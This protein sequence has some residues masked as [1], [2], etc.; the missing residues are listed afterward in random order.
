MKKI[1]KK[2]TVSLVSSSTITKIGDVLFDYANNAFLAGLNLHSLTLVG[3]YQSLESIMGVVFNLFG[4][5]I[6]D[7][8]KRKK[9]LILTDLLSGIVCIFLSL[10]YVQAW[11][12][13]AVIIA[14]IFLAFLA[15]FSSPAYKAF[16]KEVVEEDHISQI[17]SYLQTANTIVKIL[18]PIVAIW[19][20]HRIGIHGIL[21]IDG[22]SFIFSG[23][24]IVLV[25][26]IIEEVKKNEKFSLNGFYHDLISGFN[27]LFGQRT[28]F[29]LII[30]S[31]FVNFFLAAYN[32]LL[33]YGN[34]MFPRV[35]GNVYG[36]FLTAEAIGGLVGAFLSGKI[37]KQLSTNKL[38]LYLGFSGFFIAASSLFYQLTVNLFIIACAP[39]VFSLFLTIFNIQFFSFVQK[40]V[41]NEYLGRIFSIIFTVAILFMPLGTGIFTIL[42]KPNFSFNFLFIGIAIMLL[43]FIFFLLFEKIQTK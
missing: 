24:M 3:I 23:L 27:Y 8:F 21:L 12:V 22:L 2:N 13:Y 19:F 42:L 6:A 29:I 17:N 20:Y 7:Q 41:D 37:N 40:D 39:A 32:L 15:S 16:T 28:I 36:T 35:N 1:E 38:M 43:S 11:L 34:Q 14:N 9:I 4:G 10:I 26:P 18:V 33:P 31:A 5:V 30:L 25:T